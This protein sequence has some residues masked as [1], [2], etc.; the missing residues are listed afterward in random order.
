ML[1]KDPAGVPLLV[2][3]PE[4]PSAKLMAVPMG[5][6]SIP[7]SEVVGVHDASDDGTGVG[8]HVTIAVGVLVDGDGDVG[9]GVV[10]DG[11][12][13]VGGC[14]CDG[15]CDSSDV[16]VSG[17]VHVGDGVVVHDVSES[18]SPCV[19]LEVSDDSSDLVTVVVSPADGVGCDGD[20]GDVVGGPRDIAVGDLSL[21]ETDES[22]DEVV[23]GDCESGDVHIGDDGVV[24]GLSCEGT[25]KL[26][27]CDGRIDDVQV[28]GTSVEET[29][30][31][32]VVVDVDVEVGD[33][34]SLTIEGSLEHGGGSS[35][36]GPGEVVEVDVGCEEDGVSLKAA[37]VV[38]GVCQSCELGC[39][40]DGRLHGGGVDRECCDAS[41]P[42]G[43]IGDLIGDVVRREV[44]GDEHDGGHVGGCIVLHVLDGHAGGGTV[45][46]VVD[47][48]VG[49]VTCDGH[50]DG[51]GTGELGG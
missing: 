42:D 51:G 1:W 45:V 47:Y 27:A 44:V 13:E 19:V 41:V 6:H 34:V 21:E 26:S 35:D 17:D 16:T 20:G 14:L 12:R 18:E 48:R 38:D 10:G 40:V 43:G 2:G 46:V 31:T 9:D 49:D 5:V 23:S 37:A 29:E 25:D 15:S 28:A 3:A 36:G 39:G 7:E 24:S 33:R 8:D 4:I 30:E 22:S 32:C 50:G 11:G